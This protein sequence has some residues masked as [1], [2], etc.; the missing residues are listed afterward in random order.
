VR[1]RIPATPHAYDPI[2]IGPYEVLGRLGAGAMGQVY[3][4]RSAS[5]R[6]V[7]VKTIR[8]DLT[9]DTDYRE[10]FE[11]EVSAAR[12]VSGAFTAAV[13]DADAEADLPWL[14]TVYIPAPSLAALVKDCGPLPDP[15][16][17]WLAA[18][19]AEALGCIHLAGLVHRDLKPGNVLVA[20]DGPKVI[21]FGLARTDGNPHLTNAGTVMGTPSFMAPEQATGE[22]P[23]GPAA[24]VFALGA[25]LLF[26]ATGRPPYR[27]KSG[28]DAIF[29]LMTGEPDLSGVPDALREI[30]TSCLARDPGDRPTPAELVSYHAEYLT[31]P[32]S[33]PPLPAT[34]LELIEE[35]RRGPHSLP[36][37]R[38]WDRER[39]RDQDIELK[40]LVDLHSSHP[41]L[42]PGNGTPLRTVHRGV[43]RSRNVVPIAT[44]ALVVAA[45][46]GIGVF[47]GV[48]HTASATDGRPAAGSGA[49]PGGP[50]SNPPS[51]FPGGPP[52][53]FS[54]GQAPSGPPPGA[55]GGPPP[56]AY[57]VVD[58]SYLA[59][60]PPSGDPETVFDLHGSGWPPGARVSVSVVGDHAAPAR[61]TVDGSGVF[62]YSV[63]Q[64]HEFFTGAIPPGAYRIRATAGSLVE[65]VTIEVFS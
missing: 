24:D 45:A 34:A 23:V 18:C 13:V 3:L 21:D 7:A 47:Y 62:D 52:P 64:H 42:T 37:A 55:P 28:A 51:G 14:A 2:R 57:E 59:V 40:G 49:E 35:Y 20:A 22:H 6:L 56:G 44:A 39:E 12:R 27:A 15:A 9:A 29:Q 17:H 26:A 4:A 31:G 54:S 36:P 25:T 48:H 32:G 46:L 58:G 53:G 11:H 8:A 38:D 43:R 5:S 63:N 16:I 61:F 19:C 50:P 41:S 30:L 1:T 33:S 65:T 10:R 60:N